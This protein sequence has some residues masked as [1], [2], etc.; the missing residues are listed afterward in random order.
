MPG[1]PLP[2]PGVTFD[3]DQPL[4]P[5]TY[6]TID[7]EGPIELRKF[8]GGGLR[9][10]VEDIWEQY[11]AREKARQEAEAAKAVKAANANAVEVAKEPA[12]VKPPPE[13]LKMTAAQ[14]ER[15]QQRLRDIRAAE[16]EAKKKKVAQAGMFGGDMMPWLIGGAVI[17]GLV[18]M[19]QR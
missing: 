12:P 3:P 5:G 9:A 4:D 13:R 1:E 7:P 19:S 2:A 10:T 15:M 6:P 8:P 17:V 16:E 11:Q 14:L 18:A